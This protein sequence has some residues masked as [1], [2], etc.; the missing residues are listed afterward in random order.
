MSAGSEKN[1]FALVPKTPAALEKAEPGTKRVLSGMIADTLALAQEGLSMPPVELQTRCWKCGGT[2][3]E[4]PLRFECRECDFNLP[5]D[6]KGRRFKASEIEQLLRETVVGPLSG[7]RSDSN[8]SISARV[9][10]TGY[11]PSS[12]CGYGI[13]IGRGERDDGV[14]F[15]FHPG[16]LFKWYYRLRKLRLGQRSV[17][18]AR[19]EDDLVEQ[20]VWAI[21]YKEGRGVQQDFSEAFARLKMAAELGGRYDSEL[22]ENFL[23]FVTDEMESTVRQMT[24]AAIAEGERRYRESQKGH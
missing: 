20:T 7:F 13:G 3:I 24:P 1:N 18:P 6:F 22:A 9:F 19:D 14:T 11:R 2:I 4:T 23:R 16:N 15:S 5:R 21:A 12:G 10:V 17:K 8:D